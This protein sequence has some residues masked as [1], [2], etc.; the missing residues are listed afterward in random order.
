MKKK[1][2]E[3][4]ALRPCNIRQNR[5]LSSALECYEYSLIDMVNFDRRFQ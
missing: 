5:R 3:E 1:D 4:S 2:K